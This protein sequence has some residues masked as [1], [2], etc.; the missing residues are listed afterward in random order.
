VA[1]GKLPPLPIAADGAAAREVALRCADAA[2]AV[3]REAAALPRVLAE[4]GVTAGGRVDVVTTTDPA[5]ER[6]VLAILRAAY[7]DH[8][9]LGEETGGH[10][11][12]AAWTWV[13]DPIDGTRNFGLGIPFVGFNLALCYGDRPALALT[14]DPYHGETFYAEAGSGATVNGVP[15]RVAQ[16]PRLLDAVLAVD[17]GLDDVRGRAML[18]AL[19]DLFPNIQAVRVWGTVALG[20]AYVAAG[21]ID[22]YIQ[23][24]PYAWDFAPGLLLVEEAGGVVTDLT[25]GP[26]TLATRSVIAASPTIHADLV[27]AFRHVADVRSRRP[28]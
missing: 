19:H 17:L 8:A 1:P 3:L 25:G 12:E 9:I 15:L 10:A 4:K 24:S 14:A 26:M 22:A 23:P 6:A 13:I 7:P 27:Q 11:G 28:S 18:T 20:M 21:R 2:L 5:I 16:P